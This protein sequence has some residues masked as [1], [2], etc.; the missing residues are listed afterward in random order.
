[1]ALAENLAE[2]WFG[3][4]YIKVTEVPGRVV[5]RCDRGVRPPISF[6]P[7]DPESVAR[8]RRAALAHPVNRICPNCRPCL[9]VRLE[10]PNTDKLLTTFGI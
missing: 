2:N 1:M 5:A 4:K 8:A 9:L 6:N 10:D 7:G 3:Q